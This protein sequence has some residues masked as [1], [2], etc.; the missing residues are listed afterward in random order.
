LV[1]L[2]L[3]LLL[4]VVVVVVANLPFLSR[5]QFDFGFSVIFNPILVFPF[6]RRTTNL[7]KRWKTATR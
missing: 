3:L 5:K 2:L 7:L 6:T 1:L 4:L